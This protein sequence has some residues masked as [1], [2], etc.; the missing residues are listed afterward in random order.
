MR[1]CSALAL[2]AVGVVAL[3]STAGAANPRPTLSGG[4]AV[5]GHLDGSDFTG[6]I[7]FTPKGAGKFT[8]VATEKHDGT[9][10]VTWSGEGVLVNQLLKVR[11]ESVKGIAE[12][13]GD[14]DSDDKTYL[15]Y[16]AIFDARFRHA[17]VVI[18]KVAPINGTIRHR[19]IGTADLTPKTSIVQAGELAVFSKEKLKEKLG[20]LLN[21]G[22]GGDH[23]WDLNDYAH[24]SVGAQVRVLGDDERTGYMKGADEAYRAKNQKDPIWVELDANGGFRLGRDDLSFDENPSGTLTFQPAFDLDAGIKYTL[25]DQYD[26][27][28]DLA[29]DLAERGLETFKLPSD[30]DKARAMPL[31]EQRTYDG[32]ATLTLSGTLEYGP[33]FK[34]LFKDYEDLKFDAQA[35]V[36]WRHSADMKLFVERQFND[37]VHVTWNPSQQKDLGLAGS[38]VFGLIHNEDKVKALSSVKNVIAEAAF[39]QG[40]SYVTV[41]FNVGVDWVRAHDFNADALFDLSQP[42]GREGYDAL[43]H[44]DL[45][46]VDQLAAA[47]QHKGIRRWTRTDTR[48]KALETS[49]QFDVFNLLKYSHS[50]ET[51]TTHIEVQS[52]SGSSVTDSFTHNRTTDHGRTHRNLGVDST[53]KQV[54]PKDGA[55]SSALRFDVTFESDDPKTSSDKIA[56]RYLLAKVLF[57]ATNLPAVDPKVKIP[58]T[59]KLEITLGGDAIGHVLAVSDADFVADYGRACG[60][61]WDVPTA[62]RFADMDVTNPAN[63]GVHDEILRAHDAFK[64]LDRIH[65]AK[66]AANDP[67]AQARAFRDL[68]KSEG[69][70]LHAVV[71]MALVTDRSDTQVSLTI[72]SKDRTLFQ[73]EDGQAKDLPEDP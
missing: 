59:T 35:S 11:R 21:H 36:T 29:A 42:D 50:T 40:E 22:V 48:S 45:G 20:E 56:D 12:K 72:L 44:G 51:K 3:A 46:R 25:V 7:T 14:P 19:E 13:I 68:A 61:A 24:I 69:F 70:S 31:G 4:F 62:K 60:F 10:D 16:Q 52:L 43:V 33:S 71:V 37:L 18:Q 15:E 8:V 64:A 5:K 58:T 63:D 26:R 53:F 2:G 67:K 17:H 28:F 41:Q 6:T 73:Q 57:N 34:S 66:K 38:V 1:P 39:K 27:G 23:E 54:M 32:Y 65:R 30:A 49:V 9:T 47:A 55:A